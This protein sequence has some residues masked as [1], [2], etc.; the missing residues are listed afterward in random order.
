MKVALGIAI[1]IVA[2]LG[3]LYLM[4]VSFAKGAEVAAPANTGT[5]TTQTN[6]GR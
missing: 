6:Q 3:V 1:G 2:T 4:G 5:D